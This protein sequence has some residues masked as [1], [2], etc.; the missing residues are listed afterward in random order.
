MGPAELLLQPS[1]LQPLRP[2]SAASSVEARIGEMKRS[3]GAAPSPSALRRLFALS[4][5]NKDENPAGRGGVA[6]D[7]STI[8]D[9]GGSMGNTLT[10]RVAASPKLSTRSAPGAVGMRIDITVA[11]Q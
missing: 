4:H 7:R 1:R 9:H 10:S 2:K 6:T 8:S 5:D 3:G 11:V